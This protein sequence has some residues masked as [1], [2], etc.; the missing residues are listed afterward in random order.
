MDT[1]GPPN[2]PDAD[3]RLFGFRNEMFTYLQMR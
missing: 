2:G 3:K 1:I